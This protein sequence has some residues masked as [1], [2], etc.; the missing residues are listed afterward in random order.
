VHGYYVLPFLLDDRLAARLCLKSDRAG[1]TLQ[2]RTAHGE[3]G[4]DR[5]AVAEA[6]RPELRLMAEWLGL[7]RIS[8]APHGDLAPSLRDVGAGW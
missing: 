8:V 7:E 1:S 3:E 2:V 6:L 4:I 5:G